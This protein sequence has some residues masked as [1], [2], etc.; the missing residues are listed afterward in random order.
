MNI[1]LIRKQ[2]FWELYNSVNEYKALK[3]V[4]I[5]LISDEMDKLIHSAESCK[6][7]IENKEMSDEDFYKKLNEF[8][9]IKNWDS[10]DC[11]NVISMAYDTEFIGTVTI[12]T[13]MVVSRVETIGRGRELSW[14]EYT[15]GISLYILYNSEANIDTKHVYNVKEIQKLIDEK[16]IVVL[17]EKEIQL[18]SDKNYEKEKYKEFKEA[19]DSYS[20]NYEFFN[21]NGK[22]Y[23]YT[24]KYIRKQLNEEK[25]NKT[26]EKHLEHITYEMYDASRLSSMDPAWNKI[27]Q[28]CEREFNEKGYVK[29]LSKLKK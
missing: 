9:Y 14:W 6:E 1:E 10:Y 3:K 29:R 21:E 27:H 23:P 24:L 20:M 16:K 8:A 12:N 26:Y 22:F 18:D 28:S 5:S 11:Y 25:L 7:M 15:K 2:L 17:E 19:Y 13:T 4:D